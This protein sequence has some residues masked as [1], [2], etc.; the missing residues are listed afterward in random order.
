MKRS[1]YDGKPTDGVQALCDQAYERIEQREKV[2][3]P[4]NPSLCEIGGEEGGSRCRTVHRRRKEEVEVA[5]EGGSSG[6]FFAPL[7]SRRRWRSRRRGGEGI[8]PTGPARLV[9]HARC[10]AFGSTRPVR[11]IPS[12]N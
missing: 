7:V 2:T 6:V 9:S 11:S 12:L 1:D 10:D 3:V 4:A 5:P 8:S